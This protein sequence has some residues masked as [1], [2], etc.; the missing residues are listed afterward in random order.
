MDNHSLRYFMLNNL[1][2]ESGI[3]NIAKELEI[4]LGPEHQ[5]KRELDNKARPT[6]SQN[7]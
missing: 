6:A 7:V 1:T 3:K 5:E 2:I 4:N